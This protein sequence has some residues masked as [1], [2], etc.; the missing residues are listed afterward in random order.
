MRNKTAEEVLREIESGKYRDTYLI[1]N[2]RST[3]EPNLQKNSLSY[4]KAENIR[5]ASKENL[6]IAPLTIEGLC[7]DGVISEKH[8]AFKEDDEIIFGEGNTVQYKIERP[9]FYRGIEWV[10]KHYFAGMICLCWDR[11]SRNKGDDI[12]IRKTERQGARFHFTLAVYDKT[13]AGELHK[14]IDG[15]FAQHHSRVTSEKVGLTIKNSRAKGW[16]TNRAPVGYLNIGTM[17]HKPLDPERAPIIR[18][19]FEM[20]ASGGWSL[21]DLASWANQQGFT[22]PPMRRRRTKEEKAAEEE[23]DERLVI[24]A[25]CRP[26]NYNNIHNILTN[27]F[28]KGLTLDHNGVW[29]P[30]MS[31]ESIA[32][33]DLFDQVQVQLHKKN[34]SKHY[35]K[36]LGHPLRRLVCC[37]D[38]RRAFTPYPKKGIMYYGARCAANCPNP[39]KSFN[40]E[41]IADKVGTLISRLSF[42]EEELANLDARSST[43]I[44]LL[45]TRR[46]KELEY[47]ERRK[48]KIREDLAYLNTNRLDLLKTG[49][50]TPERLVADESKLNNELTNLKKLEDASDIA[51]RATVKEVVLLSELL[52]DLYPYYQNAF[53]NE[54]EEIITHIFSELSLS[55]DTLKYKCKNGFRALESRFVVDCDP[56]GNRTPI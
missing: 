4:Q 28:Y 10:N 14:D 26:A 13:S 42:T 15:M 37:D 53:P 12:L 54:K 51:M 21:S 45:E 49:A 6:P 9:K 56:T 27:P 17:E 29:I 47:A 5:F 41:Y 3:D 11:A 2:R 33:A 38:C 30:S 55:G 32:D 31:H 18:Q 43:E 7:T 40:F 35:A 22:M 23:D 16:V 34:K 44:A 1:Y 50:Y 52:K 46:L 39:K 48:K 19:L 36:V 25:V 20:Y 8:S 24:E